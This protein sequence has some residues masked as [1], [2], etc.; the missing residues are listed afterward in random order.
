ML[1]SKGNPPRG[2][3]VYLYL[4]EDGSPYY[5]GKG[6]D[7]RAWVKGK[8]EVYPPVDLSKIIIVEHSMME[9]N[10]LL[11]ET[12]LIAKY[13]RKNNNTGILR[14]KT[15]GGETFIGAV[16]TIEWN[17]KISD[18]LAGKPK[19][20]QHRKNLS[21]SRKGKKYPKLSE[22]KKGIPQTQESNLQ[23]SI[24]LSGI[25]RPQRILSCLLCQREIRL[26]GFKKHLSCCDKPT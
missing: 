3:Y 22:A 13:G 24:T 7:K 17:D 19:S 2:F 1:F 23:R 6:K 21:K 20:T 14:N 5:V 8:N 4:R 10:A 18:G 25:P 11:L 15:D 16:R 9:S 12:Q 26:N